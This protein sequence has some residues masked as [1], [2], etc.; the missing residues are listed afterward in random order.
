MNSVDK[1]RGLSALGWLIVISLAGFCLIV[2]SKLGPHYL[3]N[4]FVDESLKTLSENPAISTMTPDEILKS[5]RKNFQINNIRGKP[6]KSI[7]VKRLSKGNL[8]TIDYE[9]RIHFLHNIEVI[10]TF[11]SHLNTNRPDQCC[12]PENIE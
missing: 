1:Q 12:R 10:L 7:K 11:Q 4:R 3:D 5:L 2:V 9:E 6:A 8:V